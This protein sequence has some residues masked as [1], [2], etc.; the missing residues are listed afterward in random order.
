MGEKVRVPLR[1]RKRLLK[2]WDSREG[3]AGA[4]GGG[5]GVAV[6]GTLGVSVCVWTAARW[7]PPVLRL[8]SE[9]LSGARPDSNF[10]LWVEGGGT[11]SALRPCSLA[12]AGIVRLIALASL[13]PLVQGLG[14]FLRDVE[15]VQGLS[16]QRALPQ[17][18]LPHA[19]EPTRVTSGNTPIRPQ[20]HPPLH[21]MSLTTAFFSHSR[22]P[23]HGLLAGPVPTRKM[24]VLPSHLLGHRGFKETPP[25]MGP[26]PPI[27][28]VCA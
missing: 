15:C 13:F 7:A 11:M 14:P 3:A 26:M 28:P 18:G 27:R 6:E 9:L 16:V 1:R 20:P 23:L 5:C 12:E 24:P 8:D 10:C 25:H 21:T 4:G 2:I 19:G 17:E 22:G